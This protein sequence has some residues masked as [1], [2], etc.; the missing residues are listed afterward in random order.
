MRYTGTQFLRVLR[1]RGIPAS[2]VA[3]KV[4]CNVNLIYQ[5]KGRLQVPEAY[6]KALNALLIG[7]RAQP[8]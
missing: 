4:G 2:L 6:E 3:A 5:L 7:S 8:G 1:S